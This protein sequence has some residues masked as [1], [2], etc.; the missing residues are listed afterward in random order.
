MGETTALGPLRHDLL[1]I[2]HRWHSSL[3]TQV[4]AGFPAPLQPVTTE[5]TE[6]WYSAAAVAEAS[7]WF[8][9]YRSD[10]LHPIGFVVLRDIEQQHGTAE[11][12]ITI[13]ET[14]E[15][16]KGH[17]TEAC[18]LVLDYAFTALGLRNV[19][20][21]VYEFNRGAVRAYEKAGFRPVGRRRKAHFAAGK[22]WDVIF[23]DCLAED[24][25]SPYL[26]EALAVRAP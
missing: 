16:G 6:Q 24:F 1:A 2:Y 10:G 5:R 12:G 19:L 22:M 9:I 20:L 13:G 11:V 17:G 7:R 23:M 26:A 25:G 15:R 4:F 14:S 18:R 8:T 21:T 3:E